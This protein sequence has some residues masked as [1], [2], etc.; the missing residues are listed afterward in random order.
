MR[1]GGDWMES[2]LVVDVDVAALVVA[3]F[4]PIALLGAH[5]RLGAL[6]QSLN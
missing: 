4:S 6:W 2:S 5:W 3:V 1:I